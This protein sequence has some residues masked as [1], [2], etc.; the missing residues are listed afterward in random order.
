M[1]WRTVVITSHVKLTYK[2][3]FMVIRGE[4]LNMV[5][6]SEIH[7]LIVESL[8]VSLTSALMCELVKNKVNI[9]FC[10]EYH[11]PC[12]ELI[13]IYGA[14]NTSKKISQQINWDSIMTRTVWT[15]I[16]RQKI[17]NQDI[18]RAPV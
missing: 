15:D 10:D 18:G 13:S 3:N 2:N 11:N 1:S 14:H 6:I 16:I 9:I 8:M 17:I 12:S 4:E 7:T 5:H